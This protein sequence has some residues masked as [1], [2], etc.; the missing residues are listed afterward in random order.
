[1]HSFYKQI[2]LGTTAL[3]VGAALTVAPSSGLQAAD[4]QKQLV[5]TE[6]VVRLSDLFTDTGVAGE[7]IIME[8]PA[9][10]KKRAISNY[11]LVRLANKYALEWDRPAFLKRVYIQREGTPFNLNEL[12]GAILDLARQENLEGDVEIKVFGRKKGLFLPSDQTIEDI[13]F[14][15][16]E[17]SPQRDR[18]SA[19]LEIP[20]GTSEVFEQRISGNIEEV[21]LMPMFNRV[22]APGEVITAADL[23]WKKFP[24]RRLIR[25]AVVSSSQLI[26]KTVKRP[27]PAG[28]ILREADVSMPVM[29]SK[30]SIAFITYKSGRLTLTMQGRALEDGGSGD[31]IRLMN[32]KSKKT[33]YAKVVGENQV[34]ITA[35]GPMKLASR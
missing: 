21:R 10:G 2:K 32:Q 31:T 20:T 17:L 7:D 11:E 3:L 33:V 29:V 16:F 5:V 1:M 28:K 23:E 18:F 25:G 22:I 6:P 9:P 26:G 8:A 4:L 13:V 14:K 35:T 34:E 15:E 19:L 12:S 27:S 30:G 24:V